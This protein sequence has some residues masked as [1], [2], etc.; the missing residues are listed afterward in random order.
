MSPAQQGN[1][2]TSLGRAPTDHERPNQLAAIPNTKGDHPRGDA[3]IAR[4]DLVAPTAA[5]A[6]T[7]RVACSC[8]GLS[9]ATP[10][11]YRCS[12]LRSRGEGRGI[13][14]LGEKDLPFSRSFAV[15]HR[16]H[17]RKRLR[18]PLGAASAQ[19][20]GS[21][22]YCPPSWSLIAPNLTSAKY[23]NGSMS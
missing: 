23:F 4:L 2:T 8:R 18:Q 22:T 16:G 1:N 6:L 21:G 17:Q 19:Q 11:C 9:D 5:P 10:G 20:R 3:A 12:V 14:E 13:D 15:L 7:R